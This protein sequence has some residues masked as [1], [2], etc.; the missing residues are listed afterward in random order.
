MGRTYTPNLFACIASE[1]STL[2]SYKGHSPPYLS[3]NL[4]TLASSDGDDD[5]G[6]GRGYRIE[7]S[8]PII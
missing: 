6:D 7:Q 5:G 8:Q 4:S 1:E 2:S 3:S